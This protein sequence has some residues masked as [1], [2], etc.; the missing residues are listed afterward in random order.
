MKYHSTRGGSQDL[1]FTDVLMAGLAPDGGLYVPQ[2]WPRLTF[3][4]NDAG[5]INTA[6]SILKPFIGDTVDDE[7]LHDL[8][9]QTYTPHQ[10]GF[11]H[12][13]IT[14]IQPL[15]DHVYIMDLF[16]GPTLAFKDVALQ[17]LG[18]LLDHQLRQHNKHVTIIGATSGDTGSAAIEGCKHCDNANIVILHPHNRTS[19]VQ[20]KQMT[21]V[22][23]PN[24]HNIAIEGS[25]DDC[26][27]IVKALFANAA[28]RKQQN[29]TAV[30]S[31][32]WARI[33]AQCVYYV[34]AAQAINHPKIRFCVP[35]GNFGNIY[36]AHVMRQ[37]GLAMGGLIIASNRNDILTR[38]FETGAM[39]LTDVEP[40][41][42]PSMDIQ[43]SSNFERLLFEH[44]GS[45][46]LNQIMATFRE[47]GNAIID[48]QAFTAMKTQ[49]TAHKCDDAGTLDTIK[50]IYEETG[51]LLDPHTAVGVHAALA[52]NPSADHPIVTMACAHPAKFPDAVKQATGIHPDLPEF[53]SDLLERE[54]H[55]TILPASTD[56]VQQFIE[57]LA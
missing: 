45:A 12:P 14:P 40:S 37:S 56:A 29:L 18:R 21:T 41:L 54:E 6:L 15:K 47:T 10:D 31:I 20:R 23:A 50:M 33:L 7:T 38:F 57:G 27:N 3:P 4:D 26:Q 11:T 42:S 34:R 46:P 32:N 25:F 44:L 13:D 43:I 52:S 28:F 39:T 51:M 49:F 1:S 55:M 24:V 19:D 2:N 22:D 53:L 8:I 48:A 5:Y 17:L 36:A 9:T 35:T 30:N 16:H